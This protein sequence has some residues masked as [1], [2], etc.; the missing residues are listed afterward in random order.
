MGM[1]IEN[2]FKS[3]TVADYKKRDNVKVLIDYVSAN[4]KVKKPNGNEVL[5]QNNPD[6]IAL[7]ETFDSEI[8]KLVR[9]ARLQRP[10]RFT[11]MTTNRQKL[12]ILDLAKDE[13]FGGFGKTSASPAKITER[14]EC[15]QCIYL[16]A[17]LAEGFNNK[18][19]YF[20]DE[21]LKKYYDASKLSTTFEDIMKAE[22]GW[23][24]SA[25][26]TAQA[27]NA[28][29][30]IKKGMTFHRGDKHMK[31]IYSNAIKA[32]KNQGIESISSR[33]TD[34]YNPGDIWAFTDVK[35]I[36]KLKSD[37]IALYNEDLSKAF[38]AKKIIGISLKKAE[39][40]VPNVY[41]YNENG[42]SQLEH[43]YT[44]HFMKARKQA[45]KKFWDNQQGNIIY[46]TANEADIRSFTDFGAI[47][48]EL[49]GGAARGGKAGYT[50]LEMA[51]KE[52][53]GVDLP[54]NSSLIT[55][56]RLMKQNAKAGLND[57]TATKFYEMAKYLDPDLTEED[58]T[59]GL[60]SRT[61]GAIHSKYGATMIIYNLTKPGITQKQKDAWTKYMV[62]FA[63]SRTLY[64]SVYVLCKE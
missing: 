1:A 64:S 9:G 40:R 15:L 36:N 18:F 21:V 38:K 54:D 4:K 48:L 34:K 63:G 5:I 28:K 56:A 6:I 22:E 14:G 3:M 20:D 53:L 42:P 10:E 60:Q 17:M 46:D 52:Y 26:N 11:V 62:N 2:L 37:T 31:A 49:K 39:K 27:L 25:Y 33:N 29:G 43:V 55:D 45:G 30:Y 13:K 35:E 51:S 41:V 47:T 61:A 58:F 19:E 50:E 8:N 57:N 59:E 32:L 24:K 44:D 23:F 7:L 12:N 16:T